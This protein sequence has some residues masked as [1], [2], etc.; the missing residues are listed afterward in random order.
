MVVYHTHF[1]VNRLGFLYINNVPVPFHY[2]PTYFGCTYVCL[3]KRREI[4]FKIYEPIYIFYPS[5]P[6]YLPRNFPFKII[7]LNHIIFPPK[8]PP[9]SL[10]EEIF[11]NPTFFLGLLSMIII[12]IILI[13][14]LATTVTYGRARARG[15]GL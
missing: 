14:W 7:Y 12:V 4:Y 9:T 1:L 8:S 13:P 11:H 5:P 2:L 10:V 6:P 3:K 15:V